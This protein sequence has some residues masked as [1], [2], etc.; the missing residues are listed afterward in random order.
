M[1]LFVVYLVAVAVGFAI[2]Y[3]VTFMAVRNALDHHYKVVRWYE[4]TGE[5]LSRTGNWRQAPTA[6]GTPPTKPLP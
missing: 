3:S 1:V 2:L 6:V 5:W 4:A